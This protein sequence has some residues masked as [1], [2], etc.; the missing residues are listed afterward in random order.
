VSSCL[1]FPVHLGPRKGQHILQD[2]RGIVQAL[3]VRDPPL[4]ETGFIRL[5]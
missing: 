2:I 1:S 5:R 4:E 3:A